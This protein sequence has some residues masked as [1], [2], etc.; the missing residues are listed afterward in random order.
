MRLIRARKGQSMAEYAVLFAIVI[1]AAVAMQQYVKGRLQ[2]SVK[3]YADKY[4][5]D[6]KGGGVS[7][8]SYD[9]NRYTKSSSGTDLEFNNAK[10]G[11]VTSTSGSRSGIDKSKNR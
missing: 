4:V 6:A 2:G 8:A 3:A 9:P 10:K 1:G 5:T 7:I 11:Q